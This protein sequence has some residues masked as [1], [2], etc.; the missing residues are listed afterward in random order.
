MR[1]S[2]NQAILLLALV[3]G[4]HAIRTVHDVELPSPLTEGTMRALLSE[5][6]HKYKAHEKVAL[7]ANKV[8]PFHNPSETYQYFDLPFCPPIG[9][10]EHKSEDLGEVL[11]GD[12][13]VNTP[14]DVS[15]RVDK[16]SEHLCSREL[17][18]DDLIKFRTAV[19]E[20]YYFQMYY[21]DL[22]IWG[23]IGKI[24]KILR[25]GKPEWRYYIFT[26]I[27]FDIS[28][29]KERVIEINVSTD[30][31]RT[32]DITDG[33]NINVDFSFSVRWKETAIPFDRRM[34]KY[35][36]YSFLPQHLEIHW[37]SIIN[38]CVT[39]LL[40][41]GFLATILMRVL[42]N[43]FIKYSR[44][45]DTSDEQEETGWKYIH[46]DVFRFPPCI[47]LFCAVIGTGT[48][49]FAMVLCVFVLALVGV[50]YPYNRGSLL[51]AVI[52]LYALTAGVAGYTSSSNYKQ[53]GGGENWVRN[54]LMTCSLFCGPMFVCFCFLNT[55]AI[56][57]RS[58]AALP[59]GTIVII[60]LIW[61]LVTIPLT[62]LGGIAGKNTK[63]EFN[64]PCRTTKMPREVPP[65]PWYR[66]AVPQM[67]MAGFLP[68]SA[69][70]IELYYIFASVWGHKVYTIYSIL[71]IVFIILIIVTAFIT[72]AL[73]YFQL[74]V[75]D[76]RWW[77]RSMVCGGSTG[78]FIYGYCFYYFFA[79][80]DM[81]GF[82]QTSFFF[83]Y[84]L[85]ICYGFFLMLGTIGYRASLAFVR[86]IYKAIKCE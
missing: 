21:D 61:A 42:K 33:E 69:I 36:R 71:F 11:E 60:F 15:F 82:M 81:T 62:V 39:V 14:Y 51:T 41:T 13:L 25:P 46:G 32:V 20:D 16:E 31:M 83:G 86:H 37:F 85:M 22:P 45:D 30:P 7:Y 56:A 23:F 67:C 9:G 8:G 35:S 12:R 50:F 52:V 4:T 72:I 66:S 40:L 38:S 24:E 34:E 77:W 78:A 19:K 48:Q 65:M 27:H 63:Q 47:N 73:T 2:S 49:L 5:S 75:E 74:A 84:M 43:D 6:D 17:S 1:V 58:T 79:R 44:D 64:A 10:V 80:S 28:Y 29:N 68:F 76:H 55:V 26:H 18:K 59:F 54:V 70:Y 53:M 3:C 57:Y